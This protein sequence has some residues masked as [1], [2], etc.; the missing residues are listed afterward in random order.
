MAIP[1][2]K[3]EHLIQFGGAE[4]VEGKAYC[5]LRCPER[6]LGLRIWSMSISVG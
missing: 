4:P 2:L 1:M 6:G 3:K 5:G